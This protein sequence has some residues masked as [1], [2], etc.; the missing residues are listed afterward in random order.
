MARLRGE[1][2]RAARPRRTS[3]SGLFSPGGILR[4]I[5]PMVMSPVSCKWEHSSRTTLQS[6][7]VSCGGTPFLSGTAGREG[8]STD[9]GR[10]GR[11]RA[12]GPCAWRRHDAL[13]SSLVLTWTMTFSGL[14]QPAF[15]RA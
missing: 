14:S 4:P 3:K 10:L 13:S 15:S 9:E 5:M 12:G 8:E 1:S 7:S 6:S 2:A 11:G